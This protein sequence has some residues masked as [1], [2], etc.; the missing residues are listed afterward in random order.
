MTGTLAVSFGLQAMAVPAYQGRAG[1]SYSCPTFSYAGL[2]HCLQYLHTQPYL[3]LSGRIYLRTPVVSTRSMQGPIH[4]AYGTPH[5]VAGSRPTTPYRVLHIAYCTPTAAGPT[6]VPGN[7]YLLPVAH[8]VRDYKAC[9]GRPTAYGRPLYC[10]AYVS[11]QL[12]V[13]GYQLHRT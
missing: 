10:I 5:T 2:R 3:P 1:T 4:M 13:S 12:T 6:T 8:R 9:C 11:T 7:H